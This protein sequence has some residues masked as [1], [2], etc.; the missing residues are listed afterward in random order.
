MITRILQANANKEPLVPPEPDTWL[1]SLQLA[2]VLA[3]LYHA[4]VAVPAKA[5]F[6]A[7]KQTASEVMSQVGSLESH[8]Q[9]L[10][11]TIL[12]C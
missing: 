8:C 5:S 6:T 9:Q 12:Q 3:P 11:L 1:S 4:A 10:V 7:A 2:H